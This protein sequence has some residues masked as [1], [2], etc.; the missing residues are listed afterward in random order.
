MLTSDR[1]CLIAVEW[2]DGI[3]VV[4]QCDCG[5]VVLEWLDS[6]GVVMECEGGIKMV[7]QYGSGDAV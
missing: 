5:E 4:M 6:M 1:L 2:L 7:R 3:G